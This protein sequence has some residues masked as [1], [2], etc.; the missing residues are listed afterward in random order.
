MNRQNTGSALEVNQYFVA[1]QTNKDK[2]IPLK[3]MMTE[4]E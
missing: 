3:M 2:N 4:N 1:Y